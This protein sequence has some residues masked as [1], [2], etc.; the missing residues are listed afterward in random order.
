MAVV[1][2]PLLTDDTPHYS[3][4]CELEGV[5]YSFEFL[6]DDR[7]GA[8][9]MQI[10]DGEENPLTGMLRVVLGKSFTSQ[11]VNPALP[12]GAFFAKDT[13]NS[14]VDPGLEDLGSRVQIWYAESTSVASLQAV[15]SF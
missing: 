15:G 14:N 13:S 11:Y 6:W 9:Y 3:F 7:D 10:G 8:W 5:T 1:I 12:P 4:A 2:L